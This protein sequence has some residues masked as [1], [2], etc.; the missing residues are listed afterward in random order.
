MLKL[1]ESDA[2]RPLAHWRSS[3]KK[4]NLEKNKY[5]ILSKSLADTNDS[6]WYFFL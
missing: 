3:T 4:I 2:G 6:H 5:E 1:R